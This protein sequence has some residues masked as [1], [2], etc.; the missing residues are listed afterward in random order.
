MLSIMGRKHSTSA[1]DPI[2]NNTPTN[3]KVN[4][5]Q[6]HI[7]YF[8]CWRMYFQIYVRGPPSKLAPVAEQACSSIKQAMLKYN[9]GA[10][11]AAGAT[12]DEF[13]RA[14]ISSSDW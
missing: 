13:A 6:W 12:A 7:V 11:R 5:L 1:D 2:E 9:I 8:G 4:S 10:T 14:L 3:I